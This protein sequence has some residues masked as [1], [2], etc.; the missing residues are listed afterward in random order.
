M[1]MRLEAANAPR[2]VR[3]YLAPS[4]NTDAGQIY[5]LSVFSKYLAKVKIQ[6][7]Y[8]NLVLKQKKGFGSFFVL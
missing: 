2:L 4:F 5:A 7:L 1:Q 3:T 6:K 8:K